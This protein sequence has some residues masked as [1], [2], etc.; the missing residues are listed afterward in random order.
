MK[1]AVRYLFHKPV[2]PNSLIVDMEGQEWTHFLW[3]DKYERIWIIHPFITKP[4]ASIRDIAW[5]PLDGL[6]DS[7][8][9]DLEMA[10]KE[11]M[12][13]EYKGL[14]LKE[15][16]KEKKMKSK[17]GIVIGVFL[18]MFE[19]FVGQAQVAHPKTNNQEAAIAVMYAHP[20][21]AEKFARETVA[22]FAP[23]LET[24]K[25]TYCK[26]QYIPLY[27]AYVVNCHFNTNDAY[28]DMQSYKIQM[29][30]QV[31]PD[32]KGGVTYNALDFKE[33]R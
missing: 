14:Q 13:E 5:I 18:M 32:G 3:T 4:C 31:L 20:E 33:I 6:K 9:I 19:V 15:E 12:M 30:V 8:M 28:G 1:I 27:R 2:R 24:L 16:V 29:Q 21:L 10:C 7:E 23:D 11:L 17:I 25:I 22:S 26:A